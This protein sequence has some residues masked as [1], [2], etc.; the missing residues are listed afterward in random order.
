MV[1]HLILN[2]N[3]SPYYNALHDEAP[4]YLSDLN[5]HGPTTPF[6]LSSHPHRPHCSPRGLSVPPSIPFPLFIL[7]HSSYLSSQTKLWSQS[8][9]NPDLVCFVLCCIRISNSVW[10]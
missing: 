2:K 4:N 10:H 8:N 9:P 1:S 3:Q 5:A 7:H 6:A